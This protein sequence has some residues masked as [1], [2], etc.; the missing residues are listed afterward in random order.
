V[1]KA[2]LIQETKLLSV[3]TGMRVGVWEDE[4]NREFFRYVNG[5]LEEYDCTKYKGRLVLLKKAEKEFAEEFGNETQ[6]ETL[7]D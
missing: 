2:Q 7:L 1:T 6:K 3:E 4:N 5:Q